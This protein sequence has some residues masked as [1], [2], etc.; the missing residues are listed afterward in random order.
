[1]CQ[2]SALEL[3]SRVQWMR[4]CWP[5]PVIAEQFLDQMNGEGGVIGLTK[6]DGLAVEGCGVQRISSLVVIRS[7]KEYSSKI[8]PPLCSIK[9]K[10]SLGRSGA[11]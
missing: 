1:M 10:A 4:D 2:A 3:A 5:A 8:I 9:G 6:A 11:S 7:R